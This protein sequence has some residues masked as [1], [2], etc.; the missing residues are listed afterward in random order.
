MPINIG[1]NFVA[2]EHYIHSGVTLFTECFNPK[3]GEHIKDKEH[4]THMVYNIRTNRGREYH[5]RWGEY[6][7]GK[8]NFWEIKGW[9]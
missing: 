9:E 2:S 3:T 1:F 6:T 8:G 7:D 4:V 5:L